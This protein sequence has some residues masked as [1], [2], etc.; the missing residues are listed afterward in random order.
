MDDLLQ[1]GTSVDFRASMFTEDARR[2]DGYGQRFQNG[3]GRADLTVQVAPNLSNDSP[4]ALLAK[5][6]CLIAFSTGG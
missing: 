3:D 4:A 6:I 5:N 2:P 1:T